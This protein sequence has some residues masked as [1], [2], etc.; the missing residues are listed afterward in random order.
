MYRL[1]GIVWLIALDVGC[2]AALGAQ[3]APADS[4][5]KPDSAVQRGGNPLWG[6]PLSLLNATRD[7]PVFVPSRRPA[8]PAAAPVAAI[9]VAPPPPVS[10]EP[11]QIPLK[12]LGTIASREQRI[13]ICLN[14]TNND[15]VRLRIG[16]SFN[17]WVLRSVERREASFEKAARKTRLA[18]PS[19]EDTQTAPP[20]FAL[21]GPAASPLPVAA[22]ATP[23]PT[24]QASAPGSGTWV[25]GDGNMI[26][27]PPK[28]H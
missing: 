9:A 26:A 14:Q 22:A 23:P 1:L 5:V 27:P 7:R 25:D 28:A 4:V 3:A 16:E 18:L 13:A 15:V 11:E 10:A 6:I 21:P 2:F 19:P 24:T 20:A 17:G 8:A 12:L